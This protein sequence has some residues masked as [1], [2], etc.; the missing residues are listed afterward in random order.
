[1]AELGKEWSNALYG[2]N[3]EEEV[4]EFVFERLDASDFEDNFENVG[5]SWAEPNTLM[6]YSADEK[7]EVLYEFM[8]DLVKR[9]NKET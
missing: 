7:R 5:S 1:M 4:I 9:A 3:T 8:M 6:K 2:F